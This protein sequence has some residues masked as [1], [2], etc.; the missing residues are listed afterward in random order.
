M[1]ISTRPARSAGSRSVIRRRALRRRRTSSR[2]WPRS[3]TRSTARRSARAAAS[4]PCTRSPPTANTSSRLRCT[5]FRRASSSAPTRRSTRRIEVSVDGERVGMIDVDR[6]MS[7]ADPN[8]MVLKTKPVPVRAGAHRVTAA[9]IRTFEGP[10]N[11]NIAPIGHSIADTQI[12]SEL[13]ITNVAH[14]R[15]L[16]VTRSVQRDRRLGDAEPEEDLHLPP[17]DRGR[18]TALRR[19]DHFVDSAVP[20]IVARCS[21]KRREGA[22]DV[23]RPGRD[24]GRVRARRTHGARGDPRQPALHLPRRRAAGRRDARAALRSQP[25]RPR[26]APVVLPLGRAA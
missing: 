19:E 25:D 2:D 7:Q 22:H 10:V 23:L 9:F 13:G 5:R 16:T 24:R 8:D 18:G 1:P 26:V 17:D 21:A 14:L 20:R 3:G 15:D 6:W 11:D 12:G 4:P